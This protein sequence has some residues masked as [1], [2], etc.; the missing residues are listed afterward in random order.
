MLLTDENPFEFC[1]IQCGRFKGLN[2]S[3]FIDKKEY[4][5][6]ICNQIDWAYKFVRNYLQV[7]LTIHDIVSFEKDEILEFP[8]REIITNA[9][10]H[11]LIDVTTSTQVMVYDDRVEI[12]SPGGPYGN[13]TISKMTSGWS[14]LRNPSLAKMFKYLHLIDNWGTG[15]ERSIKM[16]NDLGIKIEVINDG[17][18]I[19]VNIYRPS[20]KP[21][22]EP[23]IKQIKSEDLTEQEQKI[24]NYLKQ[25][26]FIRRSTVE[27]IL[28][29][30]NTRA[31]QI[32]TSLIEK[33]IVMSEGKGPSVKYKL[34]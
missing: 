29:V 20:Y 31:K 8:L 23:T 18:G 6:A 27:D 16:C 7:G 13:Q 25:Y 17:I 21:T 5:G 32:I 11:R 15:L 2:R 9:Q 4:T 24:V 30:G 10:V 12:M 26:G 14:S 22:E 1:K 34:K 19:R 33:D 3:I 28:D